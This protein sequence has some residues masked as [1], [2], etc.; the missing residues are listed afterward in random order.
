MYFSSDV[1]IEIRDNTGAWHDLD[2]G[3]VD[4][5]IDGSLSEADIIPTVSVSFK[6]NVDLPA[7]LLDPTTDQQD[8]RI[9]ITEGSL[10]TYYTMQSLAGS[11]RKLYD[12]PSISGRAY[13]GIITHFPKLTYTWQTDTPAS[14]IAQ[15]VCVEH[16]STQSGRSIP[17][18][19]QATLDPTIP[20]KRYEVVRKGRLET[21]KEIAAMCAAQVRVSTDGLRFEV[22]D[23]NDKA[24]SGTANF[25]FTHAYNPANYS[26]ERIN[27]PINAV[28]VRGE[29]YD[30]SMGVLPVVRVQ[31]VPDTIPANGTSTSTAVAQVFG[32][33]GL[34][35]RHESI[36]DQA[37]DADS[38]TTIPV[39]GCYSVQGV[40]LNTG[41]Q[42]A[43][44]KGDRIN[45]T[46]FDASS[47][48]VPTQTTD[49]FI[50]SYTQ[51][52]SV[53]FSLSDYADRIDG[54]AQTSTGSLA[55][56]TTENIG[57]VV[58]VY[59]ASDTRRVG[60]NF[61][62]GGSFT[63]NTKNITLGIS[64]GAAG[65]ALIVDYLKYNGSPLSAS[66]SPS[67][68]LCDEDG[69]AESTIGSG[70][71]VGTAM[72][73]C[74]SQGQQGFARLDLTGSA[75][76]DMTLK[77]DPGAIRIKVEGSQV[78]REIENEVVSAA[79]ETDPASGISRYYFETDN[80]I[81]LVRSINFP[82]SPSLSVQNWE[83]D[84]DTPSYKVIIN[85]TPTT[86]SGE[87]GY[88]DY[89][90]VD[91]IDEADSE[92]NIT[93]TLLDS[94]G[95]PVTDGTT[96]TFEFVSRDSLGC[97]LSADSESTTDGEASVTLTAGKNSG[98]VTIRATSGG[99]HAEVTVLIS[100]EDIN[101]AAEEAQGSTGG[102]KVYVPNLDEDDTG[103]NDIAV[104]DK[105][106]RRCRI[107]DNDSNDADGSV[108][109]KRRL[110]DCDG[111]PIWGAK[112]TVN[113]VETTT[114]NLGFFRFS[115]GSTG[116]NTVTVDGK[117]Y[118]FQVSPQNSDDRG[119]WEKVCFDRDGKEVPV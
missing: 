97:T 58:G 103:D 12:Y 72:V 2:N 20:G 48:T 16:V 52:E 49:L 93:A 86:G 27:M 65:Q 63:S 106:Y 75:V 105:P 85:G 96:V 35:V 84:L 71:T 79:Q 115:N 31:C 76:G 83:N 15:Q 90:T 67:S 40:W 98:E 110:V 95:D 39:S 102:Y 60:T 26:N 70:T 66:I 33:D 59:R 5:V 3:E 4:S 54:E 64:P 108:T 116:A 37:I 36:V 82:L 62:T 107:I 91:T 22:V 50:V 69:I 32:T 101:G 113:G 100:E 46:T 104:A 45:I 25:D 81:S 1:K 42:S 23:I 38:Y 19:W 118:S 13:A 119:G 6:A 41:T 68:A 24:L 43:P 80:Q 109:G 99:Y 92:S 30:Y 21:L 73:T 57:Q 34:P 14:L 29:A 114:D 111:E 94:S 88:V 78:P 74:S 51:A 53:S 61:F 47:I 117:D 7:N 18:S 17:V 8:N 9:R 89:Q 10:V 56:S 87:G 11:V 77:A 55:V 28:R 44:V 112:V